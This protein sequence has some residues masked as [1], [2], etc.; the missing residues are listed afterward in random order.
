M[1]WGRGDH[2]SV[3]PPRCSPPYVPRLKVVGC[4][5][6]VGGRGESEL[7]LAPLAEGLAVLRLGVLHVA[8]G[9]VVRTGQG[10]KE[11]ALDDG[12]GRC[13][14]GPLER[15]RDARGLVPA[16]RHRG[17]AARR[18]HGHAVERDPLGH[19]ARRRSRRLFRRLVRGRDRRRLRHRA[20]VALLALVRLGRLGLVRLG[21]RG[22]GHRL[23]LVRRRRLGRDE[24]VGREAHRHDHADHRRPPHGPP[25]RVEV[26]RRVVAAVREG[27]QGGPRVRGSAAAAAARSAGSCH[28]RSSWVMDRSPFSFRAPAQY[29]F[30][31]IKPTN[32]YS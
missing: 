26:R 9:P 12:S 5:G 31:G 27:V 32:K 22:R 6:L 19:R 2:T 3:D 7:D 8:H 1:I 23:A 10:D 17:R 11:P 21:R 15:G 16:R 20:A 13:G 25:A 4:G 28:V 14:I 18:L 30:R 24:E 29:G